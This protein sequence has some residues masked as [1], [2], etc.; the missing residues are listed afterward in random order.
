MFLL[1]YLNIQGKL[2]SIRFELTM[3]MRKIEVLTIILRGLY[4]LLPVAL[5]YARIKTLLYNLLPFLQL[6]IYIALKKCRARGRNFTSSASMFLLIIINK[7]SIL[8]PGTISSKIRN[9][10]IFKLKIKTG[11][12]VLYFLFIKK[13]RQ[14]N[15]KIST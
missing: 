3:S 4:K 10:F 9:I 8:R 13:D 15:R 11:M 5:Y 12:P 2:S 6:N 14:I 1:P 7:I